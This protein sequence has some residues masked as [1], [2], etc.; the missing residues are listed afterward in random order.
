MPSQTNDAAI[1]TLVLVR[2]FGQLE[3]IRFEIISASGFGMDFGGDDEQ[4]GAVFV[5]ARHPKRLGVF[6]AERLQHPL[7]RRRHLLAC[8]RVAGPASR[9]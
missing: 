2:P 7:C 9:R 1:L 4:M 6:H 3:L 5:A 8:R